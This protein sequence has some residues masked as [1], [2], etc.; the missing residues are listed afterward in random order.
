MEKYEPA[1]YFGFKKYFH[2][3]KH[4]RLSFKSTN[5]SKKDQN[6]YIINGELNIKGITNEEQFTA[7]IQNNNILVTG[8]INI[9]DYNILIDKEAEKN[10]VSISMNLVLEQ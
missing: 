3:K 5:I 1:D 2:R 8:S 10:T 4:P 9:A 6:T 7:T